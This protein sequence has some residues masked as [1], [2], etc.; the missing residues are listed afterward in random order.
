MCAMLL[1]AILRGALKNRANLVVFLLVLGTNN[2][3]I[4]PS[5][6][7]C[8]CLGLFST[9]TCSIV[10]LPFHAERLKFSINHLDGFNKRNLRN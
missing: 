1:A 6:P 10:S 5:V 2:F 3:V 9:Y 8:T 4:C 7:S